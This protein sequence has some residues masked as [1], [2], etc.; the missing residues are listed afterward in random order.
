MVCHRPNEQVENCHEA[1]FYRWIV[2]RRIFTGGK[3][4]RGELLRVDS[5]EA[6]FTRW[7][8]VKRRTIAGGFARGEFLRVDSHE[9]KDQLERVCMSSPGGILSILPN[10]PSEECL[11]VKLRVVQEWW[12]SPPRREFWRPSPVIFLKIC[13]TTTKK[14]RLIVCLLLK[15]HIMG[16]KTGIWAVPE[17]RSSQCGAAHTILKSYFVEVHSCHYQLR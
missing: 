17:S 5:H 15:L 6:D 11:R 13:Y 2:T 10:K 8:I 4:S 16:S 1:N 14:M 9:L 7:K 3:L 12:R